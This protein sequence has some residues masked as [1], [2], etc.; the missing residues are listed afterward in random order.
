MFILENLFGDLSMVAK[1]ID[2]DSNK[3]LVAM[4][5]S[6]SYDAAHVRPPFHSRKKLGSSVSWILKTILKTREIE[7]HF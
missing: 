1:K 7:E 3:L 5:G 2:F 6:M 4:S